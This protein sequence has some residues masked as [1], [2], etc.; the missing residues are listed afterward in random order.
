MNRKHTISEYYKI[1]D[2]LKEI[3]PNIEFSSDFIIG[4][5]GEEE[6]F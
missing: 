3:N 2:K 6:R 4:Y 1:F 5:P